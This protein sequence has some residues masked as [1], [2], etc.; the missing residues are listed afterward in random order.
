MAYHSPKAKYTEERNGI[1]NAPRESMEAIYKGKPIITTVD[2]SMAQ[3]LLHPN[4][5]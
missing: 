1:W 3:R 4:R 2:L 5:L